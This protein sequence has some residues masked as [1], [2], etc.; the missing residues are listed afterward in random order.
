MSGSSKIWLLC[1]R[2]C[3]SNQAQYQGRWKQ[4]LHQQGAGM[5]NS[6]PGPRLGQEAVVR[7]RHSPYGHPAGLQWQG[8][9]EAKP[10]C[11]VSKFGWGPDPWRCE[12]V[13]TELPPSC[14]VAQVRAGTKP[15]VKSGSRGTHRP[16]CWLFS[17]LLLSVKELTLDSAN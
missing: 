9:S 10:G 15:Q 7:D 12:L 11:Q 16:P 13:R 4:S 17:Q 3:A 6:N 1:N 2:R 5:Y 8:R 14:P